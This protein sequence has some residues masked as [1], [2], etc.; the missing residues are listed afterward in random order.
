MIFVGPI[1]WRGRKPHARSRKDE[2]VV[3]EPDDV[4]EVK[5]TESLVQMRESEVWHFDVHETV[6]LRPFG[7]LPQ[8]V[9][10][11]TQVLE[12]MEATHEVEPRAVA[13]FL[14]ALHGDSFAVD[15]SRVT[16]V[17]LPR[18]ESMGI[19]TQRE[20]TGHELASSTAK[21]KRARGRVQQGTKSSHPR[22]GLLPTLLQVQLLRR[23]GCA[24][25]VE[26]VEA[27]VVVG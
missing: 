12:D 14:P 17:R 7:H 6:R 26:S 2:V 20:E 8:G 11:I 24:L 16:T 22:R 9:H 27:R 13:N 10:R 25:I 1:T 4:G 21:I 15:G 5:R 18:L 19:V 3:V 23:R